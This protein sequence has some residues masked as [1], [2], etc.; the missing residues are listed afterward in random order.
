[1]NETLAEAENLDIPGSIIKDDSKLPVNRYGIDR[2]FLLKK[3]LAP[4]QVDRI[5]RC[6]YVYSVG[7]F[8]LLK[9]ARLPFSQIISVWKVFAILL[10]YSCKSDY[11][12]MIA[13]IGN[14]HEK[15]KE[16][17]KIACEVMIEER[18]Q[19]LD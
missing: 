16:K 6:L 10:E 13:E 14:L 9:Q 5:Y 18:N 2:K 19:Q 4:K 11:K 12:L 7:F 15:D 17:V 1:M 3:G 8:D